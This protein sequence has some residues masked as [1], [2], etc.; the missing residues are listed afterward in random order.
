M[1][2]IIK[3]LKKDKILKTFKYINYTIIYNL[4]QMVRYFKQKKIRK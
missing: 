3:I 2:K 4:I 1:G